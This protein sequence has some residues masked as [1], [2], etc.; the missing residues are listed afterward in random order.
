MF[1]PEVMHGSPQKPMR[2]QFPPKRQEFLPTPGF[3]DRFR[4]SLSSPKSSDDSSH[5]RY[6]YLRRGVA[7]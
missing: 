6:F 4:H 1:L 7:H 5:R 2:A 3:Q